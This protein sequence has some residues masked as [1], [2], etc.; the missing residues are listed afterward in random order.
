LYLQKLSDNYHLFHAVVSTWTEPVP[1]WTDNF[2][3]PIGIMVAGGKG[4]L[5]AVL[6]DSNTTADYIPV[7]ICIQFLL[8]AAWCKAV[9][10]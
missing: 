10:R 6:A 3:G 8:L 5:R 1:G 2:N 7:D 4:F 9:G